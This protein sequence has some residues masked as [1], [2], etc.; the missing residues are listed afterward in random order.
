MF[1]FFVGIDVGKWNHHAA[2]LDSSGIHAAPDLA[3]TNTSEGFQLL[4]S[5]LNSFDKTNTVI[6]LEA[7]GH[8]WPALFS[9]LVDNFWT[10][11]VINPIQSDALRNINIR[12]T[13]TDRKDSAL[14]ADV[15]R[16]GRYTETVLPDEPILQL[17]EI[18]RCRTGLVESSGN[19]K[20][21]ILGILDRIFPEF[22]SCFSTIFGTAPTEL[23]QEFA[24]PEEL[25]NCDIEKLINLLEKESRGRHSD[26]KAKE[27]KTKAAQS[28]G[29]RMGLDALKFELRLL[30]QQL[31]FIKKQVKDIDKFLKKLMKQNEI[32]L[33]IPG[34]S[35]VLGAA[36]LG[37]IGDVKRFATPQQLQAFAGM[38]PS[39]TQSGNFTGT[40][41]KISKRGSPYLR[42]ALYLAASAARRYDPVFKEHYDKLVAR[43]KHP[44]QAMGAVATKLLR[45]IHAV[46]SSQKSYNPLKLAFSSSK[47]SF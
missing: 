44:K 20:R 29:I 4:L 2:F 1:S 45:V 7:T 10:V 27:L 47:S 15:L 32:L 25:A 43:G 11:K 33:S 17:R 38:D 46:L 3:F 35:F 36:I 30:L 23:L 42:R 14:I 12:K 26:L 9:F 16:F 6:G 5:S 39:V 22:A 41:G 21:K 19:L 37:E 8:Y 13:K 24:D 18:S 40:H 31:D 34:I 28:I